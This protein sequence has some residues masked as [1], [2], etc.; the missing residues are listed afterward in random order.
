MARV[1][2]KED[3]CVGISSID[4]QHKKLFIEIN[5]FYDNLVYKKN[6]E[7][8]L[9][10]LAELKK[11]AI[12]HFD[13]EEALMKQY[14]FPGMQRHIKEHEVFKKEIELFEKKIKDGSM[15]LSLQV[16]TFL[17]NWIM[18]HILLTDMKYSEFLVSRGAK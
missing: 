17:E 16:T 11:Y 4:I 7:A 13:T 15:V 8:L 18:N 9:L 1:E 14:G 3:Y 6:S 2:W 5:N 12:Y 10:I